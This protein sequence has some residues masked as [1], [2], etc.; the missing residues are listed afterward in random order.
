MANLKKLLRRK[1]VI[2]YLQNQL[3]VGLCGL[4]SNELMSEEDRKR[5][6]RE[7][8]RLL[9]PKAKT[10]SKTT[11][12]PVKTPERWYLDIY[13]VKYGYMKNSERRKNKGKKRKAMKRVKTVSLLKSVVAQ[14]GMVTAYK[15]GRMGLSPKTH[16]FKLRKE[17]LYAMY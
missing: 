14:D 6:T 15:E 16:A 11:E 5:I 4:D 2:A 3:K 9:N 7:L 10:Q 1:R 17:E 13:S 8:D 12:G